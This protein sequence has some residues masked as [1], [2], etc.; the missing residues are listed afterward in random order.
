MKTHKQKESTQKRRIHKTTTGIQG[1]DQITEGGLPAGRPTLLCGGAG[2]GKTLLA[3]E[4]LVRGIIDFNEPGVFISFEESKEEL[5]DNVASLGFDLDIMETDGQIYVRE[6]NLSG[7][8]VVE[9]GDYNLEG[10]FSQIGFAID[11]VGAKRIVIDGIET[12][13]SSFNDESIIRNEL[14]RLIRWL[15]DKGMSAIITSERGEGTYNITRHGI[16]EYVSDCVIFLDQRIEDQ[17]VTRRLRVV[18]YR[19][20]RHGTNEYP[21]LVTDKGISVFPITSMSLE[22]EATS[23]RVLTGVK[24]LDGMFA[25]EGYYKGSSVLVSGTAGTGKSTF[26]ASFAN[27]I[28]EDGYKCI[29]FSF[30]ESI[31]QILRNMACV[32]LDLKPYLDQNL[33]KIHAVRP[34]LQGLELHL[35]SMLSMIDQWKPAAV[36]L[37]PI[38]NLDGVAN[39][40]QIKLM[41]IRMMDF[42]KEHNITSLFTA[43]TPGSTS[44]PEATDVGVSSIMDTWIL[45]QHQP[46]NGQ[47]ERSLYILKA[48][49]INHSHQIHPFEI[50]G[51]GIEFK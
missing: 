9:L 47:R 46:N 5:Y 15:K 23:E 20:A 49:G 40:T 37:D 43:L 11:S 35:L 50:T 33:L 21:F 19:G 26:A 45:L 51:N 28:C 12:L 2:S 4:Y 29:Y 6:I 8:D 7:H 30:E 18:K 16:E 3:M 13:F 14:K 48:R 31:Q 17:V 34:T 41:F 24:K 1:L 36:I 25:G 39:L 44:F 42:L 22:H 27:A 10:L 32:G 38:T